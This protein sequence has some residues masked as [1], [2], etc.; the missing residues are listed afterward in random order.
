VGVLSAEF[1]KYVK[2]HPDEYRDQK[3]PPRRI[4][5]IKTAFGERLAAELKTSE[6]EEWLDSVQEDGDLANA[7]I[8]KLRGTFSMLYKHGKRKDLIA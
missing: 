3:N 1:L 6:I 7:T 8:N 2:A 4:D 5:R